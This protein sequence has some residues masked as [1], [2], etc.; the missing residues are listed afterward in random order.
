MF[1]KKKFNQLNFNKINFTIYIIL[2]KLFS[3]C[4]LIFFFFIEL[5]LFFKCDN[6]FCF[7]LVKFNAN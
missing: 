1:K 6:F 5:L 2:L 4:Q 3:F 7:F